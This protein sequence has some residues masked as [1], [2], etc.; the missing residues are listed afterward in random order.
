MDCLVSVVTW[1][2]AAWLEVCLDSV[3]QLR[4]PVC[5]RVFDNGSADGSVEIARRFGAEVMT[6]PRNLGFSR[7]HNLNLAEDSRW[8][9]ALVLNPDTRLDQDYVSRLREVMEGRERVGSAGGK[10]VRMD[11]EGREITVHGRPLL[12]STG[13][14]FTPSLRHFD[15]DGGRPDVG[16]RGSLEDVFGITGAGILVSREFVNDVSWR[17]E[18]LDEAF[19]AYREDADLAWRARLLG[20]RAAYVPDAVLWHARTVVPEKR[21]RL[22]V[23][24]NFHSVKNRFLMREKNM[25]SAVR[26]RCFPWYLARDAGILAYI[27]VR[28]RASLGALPAARRLRPLMREKRRDLMERR[29][30]SGAELANWFSFSPVSREL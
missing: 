25:D 13:I 6:S 21:R 11:R 2:S 19:F 22:P 3:R 28:E 10:M 18:F 30:I 26:R 8:S 9:Y 4:T 16:D 24:V 23:E 20:W 14:Y 27:L 15:R 1:N 12:D 7:G 17:G 5:L 29:R